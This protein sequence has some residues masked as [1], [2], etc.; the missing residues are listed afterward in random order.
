MEKQETMFRSTWTKIRVTIFLFLSLAVLSCNASNVADAELIK[1]VT[2]D[3]KA[4][5]KAREADDNIKALVQEALKN[6]N[7]TRPVIVLQTDEVE[8]A[9]ATAFPSIHPQEFIVV[10]TKNVS[11][12]VLES[13]IYHEIGHLHNG[14]ISLKKL[15]RDVNLIKAVSWAALATGIGCAMLCSKGKGYKALSGIG[16]FLGVATTNSIYFQYKHAAM[17]LNADRF[18]YE[19]LLKNKKIAPA[20][21]RVDYFLKAYQADPTPDWAAPLTNNYPGDLK[22]ARVGLEIMKKHGINIPDLMKNLPQDLDESV[23]TD[24]PD[25]VKKYLPEFA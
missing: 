16:G 15:E 12:Q 21:A 13:Y 6:C 1:Q 22:R 3:R 2:D 14:D 7:F 9:W 19:Q 24:L 5:F 18:G 8:G 4:Y 11:S 23:K 10:S 17:E 20:L 25:L